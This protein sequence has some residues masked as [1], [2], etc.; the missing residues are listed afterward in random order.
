MKL[1]EIAKV[2][3]NFKNSNKLMENKKS[4][5]E[6]LNAQTF[7][8][9]LK[10]KNLYADVTKES[11]YYIDEKE[12]KDLIL[13]CSVKF[14][15]VFNSNNIPFIELNN[16][17]KV[18]KVNSYEEYLESIK[19]HN[20]SE[21]MLSLVKERK[22]LQK[23]ILNKKKNLNQPFAK[24]VKNLN[25]NFN[26]KKIV[27]IDFEFFHRGSDHKLLN[28]FEFGV[29]IKDRNN[30]YTNKHYLIE[31][32]HQKKGK[33]S[34]G[35]QEKFRFGKTETISYKDV[36]NLLESY[37]ADADY[38]LFHDM[39]SE[40]RIFRQNNILFNK[41]KIKVLDTQQMQRNFES[42]IF[43][44]KKLKT[45]LYLYDIPVFD[46]HNS[47]NDAA[48]T[49]MLLMKMSDK[50]KEDKKNKKNNKKIKV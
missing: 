24:D 46:L 35:L 25:I 21:E 13:L 40:L 4:L 32:T 42:G 19:K 17:I 49:L 33:A 3:R 5:D 7:Y 31:E 48:Y 29:S 36:K 34:I 16:N 38:L 15:G 41:N 11:T 45:L 43:V 47:G 44:A 6:F 39:G 50:Y 18:Y 9:D 10:I 14:N 23:D 1:Y 37:F 2:K 28:C 27:C 12:L 8:D 26:N 20:L 30:K 22:D